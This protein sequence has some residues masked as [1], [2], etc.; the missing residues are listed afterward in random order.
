MAGRASQGVPESIYF[1]VKK[2]VAMRDKFIT[3]KVEF[4]VVDWLEC[5]KAQYQT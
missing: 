4:S 5:L 3:V 1:D 2:L